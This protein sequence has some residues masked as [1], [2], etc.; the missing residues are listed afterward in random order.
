[1]KT[2]VKTLKTNH[3]PLIA[4]SVLLLGA[5]IQLA[6]SPAHAI[7][8]PG[9]QCFANNMCRL[10]VKTPSASTPTAPLKF[11]AKSS[12]ITVN[13]SGDYSVNGD[14]ALE[15]PFGNIPLTGATNVV[16]KKGFVTNNAPSTETEGIVG[17][18]GRAK[19]PFPAK[20]F[21]AGAVAVQ[22][23]DSS[24][25]IDLGKNLEY[26]G[27]HLNPETQY[28]FFNFS[29]GLSGSIGPAQI[30]APG[31]HSVTAV[32]DP[33]D[34]YMYFGASGFSGLG[35][36]GVS[37]CNVKP[38]GCQPSG[39]ENGVGL[40]IS[41]NIPFEPINQTFFDT[42]NGHL[43]L[44]GSI[45]LGSLPLSVS[46]TAVLN[47]DADGDKVFP[48]SAK[49]YNAKYRFEQDKKHLVNLTSDIQVGATG[50]LNLEVPLLKNIFSAS[51][52]IGQG[53]AILKDSTMEQ[54][55]KFSG[56]S[57]P[58]VSSFFPKSIVDKLP[59]VQDGEVQVN[60]QLIMNTADLK[61]QEGKNAAIQS[62]KESML[63]ITGKFNV[64]ASKFAQYTGFNMGTIGAANS[65]ISISKQ[66]LN[67][68]GNSGWNIPIPY[69]NFKNNAAIDF[70]IPGENGTLSDSSFK[71][72]G[73]LSV[74]NIPLA[75]GL[76]DINRNGAFIS[77]SLNSPI[78]KF[79]L[80]GG[81]TS[82]NVNM[83][84]TA[85][86][87][88][89]T[90][91]FSKLLAPQIQSANAEFNK[92]QA[93]VN[94]LDV[95]IYKRRQ[96]VN[97]QRAPLMQQ[98]DA[99]KAAVSSAQ[100]AAD[101]S[102]YSLTWNEINR[103]YTALAATSDPFTRWWI[104][105]QI[106]GLKLTLPASKLIHEGLKKILIAAQGVLQGAQYTIDKLGAVD[107]D[108]EIVRLKGIKYTATIALNAASQVLN[109]IPLPGDFG[110]A[111][112]VTINSSGLSGYI[113]G[114]YATGGQMQIVQGTIGYVDNQVKF[115]FPYFPLPNGG[116]S[117]VC[118]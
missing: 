29:Q 13:E 89:P 31:G 58:G 79:E 60:G 101:N 102:L 118:L 36:F 114:T 68:K 27:A 44:D 22:T 49:Y 35:N 50:T 17:V 63:S 48:F 74:A 12:D 45:P 82:N 106:D 95:D 7:E 39:E 9:I 72:S 90:S 38:E 14:L 70:T 19:T 51:V 15:S 1:M 69:V 52:E 112:G 111:A 85:A 53:T 55:L 67:L 83:T 113:S 24:F 26:L 57:K 75:G 94:R 23:G 80:H 10:S 43:V 84:G 5:V 76:V 65:T 47:L 59:V 18:T 110:G 61:T 93:E 62:L 108:P 73:D 107:L 98:L 3:D 8:G 11:V 66:G 64:D 117:K 99:A 71:L 40:S 16:F 97:N 34:P 81:V 92:W 25:G 115:C 32:L 56:V 20:D 96:V 37:F 104:G 28:L 4:T 91:T 30:T 116:S 100:Y 41:G 46:G 103:L 109:N 87:N 86:I 78:T 54:S 88:I 2:K 42:F 77:G 21:A 105:L 33:S 6:S